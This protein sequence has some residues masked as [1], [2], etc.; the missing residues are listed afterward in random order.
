MQKKFKIKHEQGIYL[1]HD[2]S[3]L[4]YIPGL[5]VAYRCDY[6]SFTDMVDLKET[7]YIGESDNIHSSLNSSPNNPMS[8]DLYNNFVEKA[9]G[10]EHLGYG[11]IPMQGYTA[12]ERRMI[13]DTLISQQ[14]PL[15]NSETEKGEIHTSAIE[16]IM[17]DF[18]NGWN[19]ASKQK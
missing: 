3:T 17:E 4:P 11:V 15:I 10:K 18:P 16:L 12:D 7:L 8:Q 13:K 14:G 9:G 1:D 2:K 5:Y 6:D 19:A